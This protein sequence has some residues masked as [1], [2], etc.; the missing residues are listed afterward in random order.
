LSVDEDVAAVLVEE[1][2]T[3]LEDVAYVPLEEMLAIEGFDEEIVQELR[4]RAKDALLTKA[5]TGGGEDGE[6]PAQ[7]L[8][9]LEG[10]DEVLARRLAAAGVV[11]REDL[12]EQAVG[13]LLDIAEDL[14]EARAATLI[15]NARAHWFET[16]EEDEA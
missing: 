13:D 11:C 2:F 7:D 8:L 6:A 5:I 3:T 4:N 14:D 12:A 15:M 1:G 9:E 16:S 10:M